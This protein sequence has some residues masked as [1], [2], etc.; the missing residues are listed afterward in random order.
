MMW[1]DRCWVTQ[2]TTVG[3]KNPS[4]LKQNVQYSMAIH[5][6]IDNNYKKYS[7]NFSLKNHITLI[8]LLMVVVNSVFTL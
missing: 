6:S 1:F 5:D 7:L 2:T 4:I 8:Q 3:K